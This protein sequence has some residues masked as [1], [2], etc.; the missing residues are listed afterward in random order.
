MPYIA[1]QD[2]RKGLW[3]GLYRPN[4]AA[5]VNFLISKYYLT[6]DE[7]RI[8]DVTHFQDTVQ[9]IIEDYIQ[10]A[11]LGYQ[12]LNDLVG[13]LGCVQGEMLR[14]H[15]YKHLFNGVLKNRLSALFTEVINIYEKKKL[16]DNGDIV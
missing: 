13:V 10:D 8:D 5:E 2:R 14:R 11:G 6:F 3:E 7:K 4:T 16:E 12:I 15:N 1:S 9:S